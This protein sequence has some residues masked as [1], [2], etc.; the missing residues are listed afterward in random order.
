MDTSHAA[1]VAGSPPRPVP[2][3]REVAV[4]AIAGLVAGAAMWIVAMVI[5]AGDLGFTAPLKLVA[6]SFMGAEALDPARAVSA[7]MLGKALV[8]LMSVLFGLIFTSIL[9][10][11]AEN[12]TGLW[13]GL[14]FGVGTWLVTWF[15][16]VRVCDPILYMSGRPLSMLVLYGIYGA[17]LGVMVPLLR[18][19][20][21]E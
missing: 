3:D 21:P 11:D 17:G 8:G 9:P 15:V 20:L 1:A 16:V 14:L 2:A 10:I 13:A 18:R 4:G 7:I 12:H 6:A 19:V 5:A